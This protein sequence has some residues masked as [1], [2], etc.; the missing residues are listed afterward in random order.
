M[1]HHARNQAGSHTRGPASCTLLAAMHLAHAQARSPGFLRPNPIS[2]KHE[3]YTHACC[4]GPMQE[5][6]KRKTK[7]TLAPACVASCSMHAAALVTASG[8]AGGTMVR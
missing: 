2:R 4:S 8:C 6:Q 5:R 3:K 7:T 1:R